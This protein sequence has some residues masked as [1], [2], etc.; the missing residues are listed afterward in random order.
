MADANDPIDPE[1]QQSAYAE[2]R[3][4]MAG[5]VVTAMVLTLLLPEVPSSP[6]L[7]SSTPIWRHSTGGHDSSTTSTSGSPTR[8]L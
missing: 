6:F 4:P 7:S 8:W 1:S 5:A 2:S 3:W